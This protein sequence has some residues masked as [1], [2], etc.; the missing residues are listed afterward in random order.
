MVF[1]FTNAFH[2]LSVYLDYCLEPSSFKDRSGLFAAQMGNVETSGSDEAL[3]LSG[4]S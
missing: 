2:I 1:S 4:R 3:V